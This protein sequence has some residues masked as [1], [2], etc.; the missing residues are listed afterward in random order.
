MLLLFTC[1]K[2]IGVAWTYFPCGWFTLDSFSVD[3]F[4]TYFDK[5]FLRMNSL[6]WCNGFDGFMFH[7]TLSRT[8]FKCNNLLCLFCNVSSLTNAIAPNCYWLDLFLVNSIKMN[9]TICVMCL[10]WRSGKREWLFIE[11]LASFCL[12]EQPHQGH[13]SIWKVCVTVWCE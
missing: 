1:Y 11:T 9:K 10:F 3:G 13:V 5:T 8:T 6:H 12:A 7:V 4:W 2:A